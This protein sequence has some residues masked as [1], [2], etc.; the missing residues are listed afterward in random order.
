M[1]E[2][3][4]GEWVVRKWQFLRDV[5]IEEPLGSNSRKQAYVAINEGRSWKKCYESTMKTCREK[6]PSDHEI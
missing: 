6:F 2:R 4:D 3:D 1:T 5:L